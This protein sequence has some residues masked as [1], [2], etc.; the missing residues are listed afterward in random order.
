MS[1][2]AI[3][4][5]H[6]TADMRVLEKVSVG[7][8][9]VPKLLAELVE[10]AAVSEAVLVSTCN[11]VEVYAVVDAFH[12]GLADVVGVLARHSGLGM[13]E[14]HDHLYV[15]YA[16]AAVQHLFT[17]TAGLDSMVVGEAQILGQ[18]RLAYQAARAAGSVGRTLHELVQ[19]A[20]R[21][22]KRVHSD[23]GL[24][25]AGPSVVGEALS[26]AE[27]VLDGLA[28]RHALIVGAGSMGGLAAAA[29][30]RAAIGSVTVANRTEANGARLAASLRE[31]GVPADA[32]GLDDLPARVAEA[33]VVVACT[34]A[35]GAVVLTEHVA[36]RT[37]PLV[38]CDLGLPRD[39]E[40]GVGRV[41]GV[42]LVDL[43]SLQRRLADA[44]SGL[45]TRAA[46][47]MV[48]E[49]V[50]AYLAAQR[51]AAVT[52]TVTA[53]RR[54]AAE[55]VDSE[56]LRLDTRLPELDGAVRDELAR[57][58]RRVVDK[59]LHT[60]TVR[61][62][63]LASGPDGSGYADALR[64]LFGLDPSAPAALTAADPILD[65]RPS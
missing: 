9:D 63:E 36:A 45:D 3:G 32:V 44:P 18:V 57:T 26:D 13:G 38:V 15:H 30:R 33:D 31:Q 65:G 60:P 11:R 49:E 41:P 59:L 20:L 22:G 54:R 46:K 29:L 5:S 56:L 28:G 14:L 64:E 6:R 47:D 50:R 25:A 52:P 51:S 16:A 53:L 58:V 19:Q 7:A 40:D 4:M 2:L 10:C 48:A 27:E 12:A 39:V 35:G 37:R 61:V 43:E 17:V 24:D 23:T 55:V 8:P 1:V 42:R 34:G 62:K 21:I